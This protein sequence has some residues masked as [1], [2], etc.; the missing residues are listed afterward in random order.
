MTFLPTEQAEKDEGSPPQE[1]ICGLYRDGDEI[2]VEIRSTQTE[3][4]RI[5]RFHY[6]RLG[7]G[8]VKLD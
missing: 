8:P 2:T 5:V 4:R 1:E 6:D 3:E 7:T